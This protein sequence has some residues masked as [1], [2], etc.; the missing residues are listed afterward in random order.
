MSRPRVFVTRRI[1]QAGLDRLAAEVDL[2]VAGQDAPI[3]RADL[4]RGAASCDALLSI[5]TDTV[6]AALMD[7]SPRLKIIANYAVGTNNIDVDAATQRHIAVTNTPGVL[8]ECTADLAWTLLMDAA[9]RVTEG[10]RLT[11][12]GGFQGWGPQFMLSGDVY[13]KTLGIVGMGRIGQAVARRAS[14]FAM[15]V[16]YTK[17]Q[18]L[19]P[20]QEKELRATRVDLDTLLRNSDFVSLHCPLSPETRHLVGIRELGIMKKGAI[21][22]N[23]ARGPVVDEAALVQALRSG[24]IAGA[25]LD[26]YEDEPRLASGLAGLENAVLAPHLG[27]ATV[28]TRDRMALM[29]AENILARL[30]GERPPNLVNP[31]SIQ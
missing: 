5:L 9:R 21:L 1:P 23:T 31:A 12:A 26:V 22:V 13:G 19:D 28:E 25:G 27:S 17:R 30:K 14:G 4:E 2:Q 6:D 18:P 24:V 29:V 20:I 10:D 3:S 8:T 7:G 16:L 15:K 11:R